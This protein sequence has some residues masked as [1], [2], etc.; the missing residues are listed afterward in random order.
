MESGPVELVR[1]KERD[2][3]GRQAS[4]IDSLSNVQWSA[5]NAP[6]TYT[7]AGAVLHK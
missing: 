4:L 6:S 7:N 1:G 3:F 2:E 5:T